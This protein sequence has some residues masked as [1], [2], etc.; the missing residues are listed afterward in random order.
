VKEPFKPGNERQHLAITGILALAA[1]LM[2]V[3][4]ATAQETK[5]NSAADFETSP[6]DYNNWLTLGAGSTF[7]N[8]D[9]AQFE[10]QRDTKKGPYGGVQDFHWQQ[11]VGKSGLFTV[12]GHGMFANHDYSLRL[13]LSDPDRGFVR[14]G[15]T[16]YRTWYDGNG[17][18]FPPNH[19]SFSPYLSDLHV[20]RGSIWFETGLTLPDKPEF[21]LRYE[22][23]YRQGQMDSTSWGDNDTGSGGFPPDRKIV[24]T[25]LGVDETRDI[26]KADIKDKLGDTEAGL[27]LRY[28]IDRNNNSTYID[29]DPASSIRFVTQD[30]VEQ[31]SIFNVHGFTETFFNKKVTFSMGGSFTTMDT[32]LSGSRIYGPSYN[33]PLSP[34]YAN[35]G[36]GFTGLTGGGN[37]K[38]YVANMNLMLT[39]ID[40]LVFVPAL[41]VEYQGSDLSDDFTNT[42]VSGGTFKTTPT[43][44][45]ANNW[46]LDVA[47][48][49]EARYAGFR[50]WS[51]YARGEWSED[52]GNEVWNDQATTAIFTPVL[53]QDWTMLGQ[54]YTVG[55]NWY[56]LYRLNFGGQYYHEIHDYDYDNNLIAKPVI[57]PGYLQNQNF[58]VDDMNFRAT[59]RALNT[60]SL[61]TLYDFQYSTVNTRAIPNGG[62]QAGEVESASFTSHIISENV[63]WTPFS[64]LYVQAGGSYVLNSLDTP[65]AS[66]SG[67]NNLV[68]N[69]ASDYWTANTTIGYA[70]DEKTDLQLQYSYYHADNYINNSA[71]SQPFGAGDEQHSV[72]ATVTRRIS[73][74]LQV[75]LK[76]GFYRN[77]DETSGGLNNYDAQLVYA[78]MQYR[79]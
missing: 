22:H 79:F 47:Q 39:P 58:T 55:A 37:T 74:A 31:D 70:L 52:S 4:P 64:R 50:N 46:Y 45:G 21:T 76:Y 29:L 15:F 43:T 28:E 40:D 12:D 17:G 42:S 11:F 38:E 66:S 57:Y 59:W 33:A 56:P 75:S 63:S 72:T 54:K 9:K 24:P 20:D 27:G 7:V 25:F 32:D 49:M 48:S 36:S 34:G 30:S 13:D 69:S 5:T 35:N 41:R 77:R 51:L 65:V 44:A 16:E 23:D 8:G 60:L 62:A 19:P 71:S 53:N 6:A 78:T 2:G 67:I 73:K 10:H 61:V 26:V 1:S 18:F 14:A 68:L 3:L